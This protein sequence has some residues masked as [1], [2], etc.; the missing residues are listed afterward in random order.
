MDRRSLIISVG[1]HVSVA[2]LAWIGLPSIKRDLP[3]EQPIVVMEMVQSVP[4]TNLTQGDK[5]NT[6]KKEQ[7]AAKSKKPPPPPPPA[8]PR[9]KPPAPK[10]VAKPSPKA[11]DPK[12]EILPQKITPKPKPKPAIAQPPAPP[13][14]KPKT[15]ATIK[16]PKRLPQSP[17]KRINKLARQKASQKQREDALSGVMQNLAKAKAVSEEAE[18]KRRE[19]E[20]KEAAETLTSNLTTAAGNAVRAPQKPVVGPLGLSDIDRIRQHVSS[21]WSPPIGTAGANTLIV[22]IIVTLDRDGKVLTAEVDN[23]MRLAT[24]RTYRVAADEAIRTMF[25]C[26]PL[27]VPLDKYE[28]WKSFIFGFDPKFLTR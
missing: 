19:K 21:C 20:R 25:K 27:P 15:A 5:P 9:A 13:K 3:E 17:P 23:K 2:V 8:P 12:A 28:Q 26:S 24:D 7:K 1:L 14:S 4:T 18:K 16:A 10:P 11:P 6:A 22:D